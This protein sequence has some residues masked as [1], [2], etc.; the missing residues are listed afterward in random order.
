MKLVVTV[1]ITHLGCVPT[2]PHCRLNLCRIGVGNVVTL[3]QQRLEAV[4]L[5]GGEQDVCLVR[6]RIDNT[7]RAI[8]VLVERLLQFG[9]ESDHKE[10]LSPPDSLRQTNIWILAAWTSRS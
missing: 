2:S 5:R 1:V 4:V 6:A 8:R 9:G 7:G 3:L 10:I